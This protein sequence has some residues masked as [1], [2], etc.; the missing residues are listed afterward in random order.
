MRYI[1]FLPL[2]AFFIA[3]NAQSK[4][5]IFV[6]LNKKTNA[7]ELAK[8][9]VERLMKG[10]MA[11]IERLA[12]EEKLLVAGPFEGGG[13]LFILNTTS[14]DEASDWLKTDPGIQ[15]NRWDVEMLVYSPQVGSVCAV[16]EPFEMVS[17]DFIRFYKAAGGKAN[18]LSEHRQIVKKESEHGNVVTSGEFKP[19]GN[20]LILKNGVMQ[21]FLE[22]DP[23]VQSGILKPETKKLW[24]AKGSFCEK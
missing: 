15:A 24:I 8:D 1:L 23:A 22:T 5:Y 2:I 3:A 4:S 16:K 14:M 17:Y 19:S 11:N 20:I 13:G 7:S 12:K 10:H 21:K 6:F 9:S 18:E